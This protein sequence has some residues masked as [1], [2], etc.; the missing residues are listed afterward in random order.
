MAH[1]FLALFETPHEAQLAIDALIDA[2]VPKSKLSLIMP[3]E[4]LHQGETFQDL[5]ESTRTA[6]RIE[7]GMATG[8]TAGGALGAIAG[9]SVAAIP[10]VGPAAIAAAGLGAIA[11]GLG[12][13][14]ND[15]GLPENQTEFLNE[16]LKDGHALLYARIETDGLKAQEIQAIVQSILQERGAMQIASRNDSERTAQ[17]K[18]PP[19]PLP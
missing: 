9:A 16:K 14:I 4:R 5:D 11:G 6:K 8:T 3:D 13:T 12:G 18:N 1:A 10:G 19:T 7:K 2:G 17:G 15:L